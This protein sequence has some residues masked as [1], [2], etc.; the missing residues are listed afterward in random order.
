MPLYSWTLITRNSSMVDRDARK[1]GEFKAA[2]PTEAKKKVDE[3]TGS[4]DWNKKWRKEQ[5]TYVN[6]WVKF[7][8]DGRSEYWPCVYLDELR[9]V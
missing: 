6:T 3:L 5:S 7:K 2:T 1:R 4:G 8:N 9:E